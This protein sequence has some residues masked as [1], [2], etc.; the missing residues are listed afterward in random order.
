MIGEIN[1]KT[2]IHF[3]LLLVEKY[4]LKLRTIR[5]VTQDFFKSVFTITYTIL[6]YRI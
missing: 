1:L 2:T 3:K 6:H 5:K 4:E